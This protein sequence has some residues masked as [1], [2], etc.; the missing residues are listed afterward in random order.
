MPE[1]K[2]EEASEDQKRRARA[3]YTQY[4]ALREF[5]N[6]ASLPI[7]KYL[8]NERGEHLFVETFVR[9]S[10]RN[11]FEFFNRVEIDVKEKIVMNILFNE[12]LY[13]HDF[14]YDVKKNSSTG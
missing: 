5:Q 8:F 13:A 4:D 10:N 1:F 12:T 14:L 6:K 3:V 9:K 7:F 2:Y 11:I